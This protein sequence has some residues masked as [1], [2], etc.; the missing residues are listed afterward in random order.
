MTAEEIAFRIKLADKDFEKY[1]NGNGWR[2]NKSPTGAHYW[3]GAGENGQYLVCRHCGIEQGKEDYK[4][5][6]RER[7]ESRTQ[8][9]QTAEDAMVK[10]LGLT[11]TTEERL[12]VARVELA[13]AVGEEHGDGAVAV[14]E[15][16]VRQLEEMEKEESKARSPKRAK[17]QESRQN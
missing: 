4:R 14:W 6:E 7:L 13:R 1:R 15:H 8:G 17:K 10:A 11:G 12:L 16:K 5:E 2:C 9:T 3:A